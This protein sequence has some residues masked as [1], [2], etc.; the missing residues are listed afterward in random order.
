MQWKNVF[1]GIPGGV[2]TMVGSSNI[3]GGGFLPPVD[4]NDKIIVA[5]ACALVLEILYRHDVHA[6]DG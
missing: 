3:Q 2:V 5:C 6:R 1:F 4:G